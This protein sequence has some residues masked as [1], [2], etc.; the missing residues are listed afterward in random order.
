[1]W[2]LQVLRTE[3]ATAAPASAQELHHDRPG[4][5]ERPPRPGETAEWLDVRA[6]AR[7][8]ASS[9]EPMRPIADAFSGEAGTCWGRQS[10]AR[11]SSSCGLIRRVTWHEYD[12]CS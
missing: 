4:E 9:E 8:H 7:A 11:G 1:V 10:R 2:S 3:A 12:S 6:I 5:K